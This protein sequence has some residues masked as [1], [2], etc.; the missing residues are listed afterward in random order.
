MKYWEVTLFQLPENVCIRGLEPTGEPGWTWEE[1]SY[2]RLWK[3]G[4]FVGLP[5]LLY[6]IGWAAQQFGKALRNQKEKQLLNF[7]A[8]PGPTVGYVSH[9]G[10]LDLWLGI[11]ADLLSLWEK[12]KRTM[13]EW[14]DWRIKI[15]TS[16]INKRL[17]Y[18]RIIRQII[19]SHHSNQKCNDLI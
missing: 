18:C 9:R 12:R 8:D 14:I 13:H 2:Y 17:A 1:Y 6:V 7:R 10:T 11:R 3:W 5:G 4:G 16:C 19:S 15:M